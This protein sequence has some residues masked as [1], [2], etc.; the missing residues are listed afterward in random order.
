[1]HFSNA[2]ESGILIADWSDKDIRKQSN[3]AHLIKT[4]QPA[5]T[6]ANR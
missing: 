6:N 4:T 1:M 3:T 2:F 5:V